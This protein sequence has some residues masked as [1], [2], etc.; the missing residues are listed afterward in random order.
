MTVRTIA[1][2]LLLATAFALATAGFGWWTVPIVGALWGIIAP[3][4]RHPARLAAL[5]APLAWGALLVWG[6]MHGPV[7]ALAT[8][9]AGVLHV[10]APVLIAVTL[11]FPAA[12]A[13]SSAV[14]GGV[15]GRRAAT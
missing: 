13:W 4:R 2:T 8:R 10:P 6:A 15:A 7:P 11:I 9:L 14:V 5:A 1:R 3:D 12:L